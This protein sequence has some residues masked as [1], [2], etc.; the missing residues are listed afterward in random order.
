MQL[1]QKKI[2]NLELFKNKTIE[3]NDMINNI[4]FDVS[5][6]VLL[7]GAC[8]EK[9]V[10]IEEEVT[11]D[12]RILYKEESMNTEK[13]FRKRYGIPDNYE[14]EDIEMVSP[15]ALDEYNQ[16]IKR[17][18]KT[19]FGGT[20]KNIVKVNKSLFNMSNMA[21]YKLLI[22]RDQ[23]CLDILNDKSSAYYLSLCNLLGE[24]KINFTFFI[25]S[26]NLFTFD[27]YR[28][29]TYIN[30]RT[31]L[32]K[33][34]FTDALK[35]IF[36]DSCLK[37]SSGS[38]DNLWDEDIDNKRFHIL[39]EVTI[40]NNIM[41]K[42]KQ[43]TGNKTI[44]LNRKSSAIQNDANIQFYNPI[45]CNN[46]SRIRITGSLDE[47]E[48]V[49]NRFNYIN[50]QHDDIVTGKELTDGLDFKFDV[51]Y[52][53]IAMRLIGSY[54]YL[55]DNIDF[56][57][58]LINEYETVQLNGSGPIKTCSR[59]MIELIDTATE[60]KSSDNDYNALSY[61]FITT[62][63]NY[64]STGKIDFLVDFVNG[65]DYN[66]INKIV[67]DK[68]NSGSISKAIFDAWN[69]SFGCNWNEKYVKSLKLNEINFIYKNILGGTDNITPKKIGLK[70]DSNKRY[71]N[72]SI[73]IEKDILINVFTNS[74]HNRVEV[75]EVE[76]N[77]FLTKFVSMDDI[78]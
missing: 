2:D 10:A 65:N 24:D 26:L 19:V 34:I 14:L 16:L 47:F 38:V 43:Y 57:N 35:E 18:T 77:D 31:M 32:G 54:M 76:E 59:D 30:G 51:Y 45:V 68:Y 23:R 72:N 73:I 36:L 15:S 64:N 69:R 12:G 17:E 39:D 46:N 1:L 75:K 22:N 5:N 4:K 25:W 7:V 48:S 55:E 21:M 53:Y 58:K 27:N 41:N 63:R 6:N 60:K 8:G 52:K 37:S 70:N 28:S 74:I 66:Q 11:S 61:K 33:S 50:R 9:F 20:V 71:N 44:S 78:M 42:L 49:L 40:N 29:I 56:K 3:I 67:K 62:I 13:K